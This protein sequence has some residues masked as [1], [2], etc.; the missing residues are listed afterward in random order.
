MEKKCSKK[1]EAKYIAYIEKYYSDIFQYIRIDKKNTRYFIVVRCKKC[2]T[3]MSGII[4]KF[5]EGTSCKCDK[6]GKNRISA[7]RYA[8]ELFVSLDKD[9]AG[10]LVGKELEEYIDWSLPFDRPTIGK[11]PEYREMVHNFIIDIYEDHDVVRCSECGILLSQRRMHSYF[12]DNC[13]DCARTK[14]RTDMRG[15]KRKDD[16]I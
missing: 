16:T 5:K 1:I 3:E 12:R 14:P 2:G 10:L 13:K 4:D 6:S 8:R 15:R 9:K 7:W 11:N